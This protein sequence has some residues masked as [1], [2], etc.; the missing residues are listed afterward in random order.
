MKWHKRSLGLIRG[1]GSTNSNKVIELAVN[2]LNQFG[3]DIDKGV[4]VS[5]TNAASVSVQFNML[6]YKI[7]FQYLKKIIIRVFVHVTNINKHGYIC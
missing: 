5:T 2:K 4:A 1:V 6:L 3:L 7:V